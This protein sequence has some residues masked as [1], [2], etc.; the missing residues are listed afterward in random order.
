MKRL[1]VLLCALCLTLATSSCIYSINI[2]NGKR[3]VCKGEVQTREM[4]LGNFTQLVMNGSAD[5]IL[6]QTDTFGVKVTANEEVFEYLDF[7]VEDGVLILE[8]AKDGKTVQLVA[9]T[10]KI[11]VSAPLL[12]NITANGATDAELSSYSSDK[13]ISIAVNGA[14]DFKLSDIKVPTLRFTINGAG[15][16]EAKALDTEN[17][18]VSV[19]GAGDIEVAGKAGYASFSVTGAGDIDARELDC[20]KVDKHKSGAASIRLKKD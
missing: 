4:E 20:P 11:Y 18:Y 5:I 3:I 6:S 7:R 2:N 17:L 12:E 14:G 15:D 9:K 1:S 19:N 8:T 13:D 16:M 10:F